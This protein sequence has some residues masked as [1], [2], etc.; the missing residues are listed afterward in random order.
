MAYVPIDRANTR[1]LLAA[2][3][4]PIA[5]EL[6]ARLIE[7]E[8]ERERL[9]ERMRALLARV[10]ATETLVSELTDSMGGPPEMG[11]MRKNRKRARK[12][13]DATIAAGEAPLGAMMASAITKGRKT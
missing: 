9:R 2:V 13:D 10:T 7:L 8:D 4:A 11:A 12:V 6:F 5:D 3:G 1:R